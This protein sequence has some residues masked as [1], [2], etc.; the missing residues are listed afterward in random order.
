[1]KRRGSRGP[2]P[3][4]RWRDER[5]SR[6]LVATA[7]LALLASPAV[8]EPELTET[9]RTL[10]SET[11]RLAEE[12]GEEI[13]PGWGAAPWEVLLVGAEHQFLVNSPRR[14]EGFT[15]LA[16]DELL[17]GR[18]LVAPRS[19][20]PGLRATYPIL[21][22]PP[23]VVVGRPEATGL[24]PT[25][26]VAMVLHEHFHQLQMS[27][28]DYH[29]DVA[30]LDLAGGDESGQWML[31]FPF[32]YD[33]PQV[34]T[35]FRGLTE[36]IRA[37]LTG[38]VPP[39]WV[40]EAMGAL[41]AVLPAAAN[42]Y[43]GFQLWQEGVARYVQLRVAR[44]AGERFTPSAEFVALSGYRPFAEVADE[45]ERQ[46]LDELAAPRLA[47]R[48]RVAFY[49]AGAGL[50]MLLDRHSAGWQELYPRRKFELEALLP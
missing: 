15:E 46:I 14:P 7:L 39:E 9:D 33:A 43:L 24:D 5:M 25:A 48:R 17:E 36:T 22:G 28:S 37:G 10:L 32:P 3:A 40:V 8:A 16:R 41:A 38:D 6:L 50:A 2:H 23:V 20:S 42:R 27:D 19:V 30:A 21:G 49:A 1:M 18:V 29:A 11:F 35:L 26:W 13:W 47:E 44:V 45:L 4:D 34:N 12:L 31:D